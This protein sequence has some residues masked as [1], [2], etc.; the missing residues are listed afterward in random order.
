MLYEQAIKY[1][2]EH[3][4]MDNYIMTIVSRESFDYYRIGLLQSNANLYLF[5]NIF[6][7]TVIEIVVFWYLFDFIDNGGFV[8]LKKKLKIYVSIFVC[9]ILCLPSLPVSAD[10]ANFFKVITP[11]II[12]ERF[13]SQYSVSWVANQFQKSE[14]YFEGYDLELFNDLH[15]MDV[16]PLGDRVL[17]SLGAFNVSTGN[18][19]LVIMDL[20]HTTG[21]YHS[22]FVQTQGITVVFDEEQ[23][24][25]SYVGLYSYLYNPSTGW[26]TYYSSSTQGINS[27]P[28]MTFT[29]ASSNTRENPNKP[30]IWMG[31]VGLQTYNNEMVYFA[32]YGSSLTEYMYYTNCEHYYSSKEFWDLY[33]NDNTALAS[34]ISNYF[35]VYSIVSG[36]KIDTVDLTDYAN[37]SPYWDGNEIIDPSGGGGGVVIEDNTNHLY[38]KNVNAGFCKPR[39][40]KNL[41][42]VG[43]GYLYFSYDFDD[44]LNYHNF[45]YDFQITSD[46]NIDGN[47]YGSVIRQPLDL[48]GISVLPFSD[49]GNLIN[50][51]GENIIFVESTEQILS[52]Y[53]LGY[54]YSMPYAKFIQNRNVIQGN[55]TPWVY[56]TTYGVDILGYDLS[57]DFST[58]I[59]NLF[60]SQVNHTT[61]TLTVSCKLI[62]KVSNQESGTFT[63]TFNLLTGVST[64]SDK[65]I[66]DN[67]NPFE[68][69]EDDVFLPVDDKGGGY[70]VIGSGDNNQIVNFTTP[71]DIK[72]FIDNGLHNFIS[73][74]NSD[75]STAEVSN[76]FWSSFGIF[77]NNPAIDLYEDYW[78]FLPDGFKNIIIGCATIGIVGG[79]FSALRRKFT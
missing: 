40:M 35:G 67:R 49:L 26:S 4:V 72:L 1:L 65:S 30:G 11:D 66:E 39:S 10:G 63:K 46:F 25:G 56:L 6:T 24:S 58:S 55:L 43:G 2:F 75:P 18:T 51:N 59:E 79:V 62:D 33:Y 12:S 8:M 64:T 17:Y 77:R 44:W 52:T 74:Y 22:A 15:I 57:N 47:H 21:T 36:G 19:Q 71:S 42:N 13:P 38:L 76:G 28:K 78:G 20:S 41:S 70:Q 68:N 34:S 14:T 23:P 9:I 54:V 5:L 53:N 73:W 32:N 16:N 31:N 61:F 50:W 29:F 60:V 48:Q 69:S 27:T 7:F 37:N 45:D 3:M